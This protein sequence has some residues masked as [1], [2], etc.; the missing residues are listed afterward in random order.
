MR[1]VFHAAEAAGWLPSG[2]RLDFMGFGLVQGQDG[3]SPHPRPRQTGVLDAAVSAHVDLCQNG[4]GGDEQKYLH[5]ALTL[6]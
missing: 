1:M 5:V 2:Q 6:T 3:A 4:G